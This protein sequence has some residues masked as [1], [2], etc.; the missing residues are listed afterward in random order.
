VEI[1]LV[2]LVGKGQTLR[3][4]VEGDAVPRTFIPQLIELWRDGRFPVDQ[5]ITTFPFEQI[6]DAI[7]STNRA[8]T[9]KPVLTFPT[10]AG[11]G[12]RPS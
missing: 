9:V 1:D 4:V 2:K 7:D 3:G 6:N 10:T 12:P 11:H 8:D 5:L